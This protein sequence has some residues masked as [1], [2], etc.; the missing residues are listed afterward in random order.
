MVRTL[1]PCGTPAA[2]SRHTRRRE[3][4]CE[5]CTTAWRKYARRRVKIRRRDPVRHAAL[6]ERKAKRDQMAVL[7][8]QGAAVADA[9]EALRGDTEGDLVA[10]PGPTLLDGLAALVE[11]GVL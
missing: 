11:R 9:L 4:P 1:K 7:D 6:L 2:Y 3:V 10:L 5:R 8:M